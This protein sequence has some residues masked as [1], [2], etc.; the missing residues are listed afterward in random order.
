MKPKHLSLDG[1]ELEFDVT[2]QIDPA[3]AD[4][5]RQRRDDVFAF[6]FDFDEPEFALD[7]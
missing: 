6:P 2:Q 4:S 7:L 1:P 5:L 3:L